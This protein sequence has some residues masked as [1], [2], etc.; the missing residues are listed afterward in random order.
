ML[1]RHVISVCASTHSSWKRHLNKA[2]WC[3]RRK[4]MI[5]EVISNCRGGKYYKPH[6]CELSLLR[7]EN[8]TAQKKHQIDSGLKMEK[9]KSWKSF[10]FKNKLY[11]WWF[12]PVLQRQ[13]FTK[14]MQK[15][16]DSDSNRGEICNTIRGMLPIFNLHKI[17]FGKKNHQNTKKH[18]APLSNSRTRNP[19]GTPYRT[20]VTN[21]G[22]CFRIDLYS[23][24]T[25][26]QQYKQHKPFLRKQRLG[27][28]NAFS[29]SN[30]ETKL[31]NGG[32]LTMGSKKYCVAAKSVY[33]RGRPICDGGYGGLYSFKT[34]LWIY[35]YYR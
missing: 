30:S 25:S 3:H 29:W 12:T 21:R 22:K 7:G 5:S 26:K 24:W 35:V 31:M 14:K 8:I 1:I 17:R 11:W 23:K 9:G 33:R 27:S 20:A 18:G 28:T 2:G 34:M 4:I 15:Y 19:W 32:Q 10:T 16:C 6:T 13:L